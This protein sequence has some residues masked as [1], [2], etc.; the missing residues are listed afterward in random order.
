M[1]YRYH[2]RD[3]KQRIYTGIPEDLRDVDSARY[4]RFAEEGQAEEIVTLLRE[5]FD[6][7]ESHLKDLRQISGMIEK[8]WIRVVSEEGRIVA[9]L[10]AIPQGRRLYIEQVLNR[11]KRE[12]IHC[13]YL[14]ALE[15]AV[16]SGISYAYTWVKDGNEKGEGIAVRY[17]HEKDGTADSIFVKGKRT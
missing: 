15:E 1:F 3:L 17:G 10:S 2:I 14:Y 16:R 4:G 12:Y 5:T 11:G 13:L 8:G 6:A 9:L 7:R